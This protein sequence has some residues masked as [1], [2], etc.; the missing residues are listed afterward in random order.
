MLGP[1]FTLSTLCSPVIGLSQI[2]AAACEAGLQGIDLD[3]ATPFRRWRHAHQVPIPGSA[4]TEWTIWLPSGGFHG[5]HLDSRLAAMWEQMAHKG[6]Q[7]TVIVPEDGA[8]A[9]VMASRQLRQ[10]T[11]LQRQ[12]TTPGRV[13]LAL[14]PRNPDGG[15]AHLVHLSTLRAIAEE[16]DLDLALDLTGHVDWL[17]EAEAAVYRMMPRLSLIRLIFPL[18]RLD[19][20]VRTRMTR[21]VLAAAIDAGFAGTIALAVPLPPWHWRDVRALA[22]VAA[23]A[24]S[25]L[26]ERFSTGAP[27]AR[28]DLPQ[29]Y[30]LPHQ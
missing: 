22:R 13:A 6:Q 12:Q 17:W 2:H 9:S 4:I 18:P 30:Y 10:A 28:R 15:H 21:R 26:S 14:H 20:H 7:V 3:L 27:H 29:R 8:N 24:A 1:A 5:D 16:W 11:A 25:Q 19:A 23:S